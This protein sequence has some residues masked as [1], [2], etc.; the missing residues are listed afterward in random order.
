MT[1]GFSGLLPPAPLGRF[2]VRPGAAPALLL[3]WTSVNPPVPLSFFFSCR[4]SVAGSWL[5]AMASLHAGGC[6]VSPEGPE[7]SGGAAKRLDASWPPASSH[8]TS[9]LSP[10][11]AKPA[12][13][14]AWAFS[15]SCLPV[16]GSPSTLSV[17][18]GRGGCCHFLLVGYP[19]LRDPAAP[20]IDAG[21][22]STV[23]R[24][25]LMASFRAT[26]QMAF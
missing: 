10:L 14:A 12:F 26:A 17:R 4:P 9:S 25:S 13:N 16:A 21:D 18:A 7:R 6:G 11:I 5:P 19:D 20:S 24:Q 15:Y 8:S 22:V 3:M 2:R 23:R 1:E